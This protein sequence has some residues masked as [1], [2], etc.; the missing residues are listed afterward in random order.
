MHT[1]R[2]EGEKCTSDAPQVLDFDIEAMFSELDTRKPGEGSK[3][4]TTQEIKNRLGI[5][6]PRTVSLIKAALAAGR[7]RVIRKKIIGMD[8]RSTTVPAYLFGE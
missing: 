1:A 3:G 7:C 2:L 5:G 6:L 8:G 4:L